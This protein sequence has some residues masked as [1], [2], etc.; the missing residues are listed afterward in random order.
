MGV[1]QNQRTP[2]KNIIDKPVT[3]DIDQISAF[4]VVY[5]SG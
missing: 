4:T 2:Q 1:P 3:V 5:E